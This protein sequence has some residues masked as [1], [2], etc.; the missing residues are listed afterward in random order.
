MNSF[1]DIS[2]VNNRATAVLTSL[3]ASIREG[4]MNRDPSGN[5]TITPHP[6]MPGPDGQPM[7]PVQDTPA[8]VLLGQ[9]YIMASFEPHE[10]EEAEELVKE[11]N[12]HL[13]PLSAK[14]EKKYLADIRKL[15]K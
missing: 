7:T 3:R 14:L 12:E 10:R 8:H 1:Q 5:I 6:R 13:E 11:L 2:R 9:N 4:V 15:L